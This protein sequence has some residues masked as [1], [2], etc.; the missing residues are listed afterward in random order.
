M[1]DFL[2]DFIVV[3]QPFVQFSQFILL[4]QDLFSIKYRYFRSTYK[5]ITLAFDVL[6]VSVLGVRLSHE[7]NQ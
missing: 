5:L 2:L 3:L 1:N 7:Q 6:A 4:L